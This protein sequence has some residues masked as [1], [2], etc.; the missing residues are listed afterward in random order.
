MQL[1]LRVTARATIWRWFVV[2]LPGVLLYLLPLPLLRPDQ[3]HLVAFFVATIVALIVQPMAMGACILLSMTALALTNTL[4]PTVVLS[5]F[6]DPTVW[7]IF[8]AFL[9]SRAVTDTRLGTRV[10]YLFIR[11]FG[12]NALTLGYS[13]SISDLVLAP[14]VP[15][16]TAR[17]GGIIC[18]ITKSVAE[19]LGSEPGTDSGKMGGFLVLV[20]FHTTY[21]ASA[22]F[23]TGMA[24]N[25]LMAD[26]A[27]KIGHVEMTWIRWFLGAIVPGGICLVLIPLLLYR[28][29]R[30]A[31]TDTEAA[32]IHARLELDRMG[33]LSP[34][35]WRLGVIMLLVMAGWVTSPVA[36]HS[37]CIRGSGRCIRDPGYKRTDME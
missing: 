29:Y 1:Q 11:K 36:P 24:A 14:F 34:R 25:P 31:S 19:A 4:P 20:A 9:F 13:I 35:E 21:I 26:F 23:L 28:F 12:R 15:S 17:G 2:L 5:G 32:R 3:R 30:P 7:L 27:L 22:M 6:S 16:D 33:R 37:E 10:A 18:P 8:T